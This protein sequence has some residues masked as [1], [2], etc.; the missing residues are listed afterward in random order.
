MGFD[1]VDTY[2][3][4]SANIF[5]SES[6]YIACVEI[7]VRVVPETNMVAAS[8]RSVDAQCRCTGPGH[9]TYFKSPMKPLRKIQIIQE[10]IPLDQ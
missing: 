6:A 9:V 8:L 10:F 5:F 1:K 2:F 3:L 7:M 4:E